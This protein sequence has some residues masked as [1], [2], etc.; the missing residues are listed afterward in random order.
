VLAARGPNA[1]PAMNLVILNTHSVRNS[2]DAAIVEAQLALLRELLPDPHITLTSRTPAEDAGFYAHLGVAAVLPPLFAA[3][4]IFPTS[5]RKLAGVAR[6]ALAFDAR[7]RLREAIRSA[8]LVVASGGGYLFSNRRRFPGPMFWQAWL[9][10]R[11]ALRAGRPVIFAPQSFG[12]FANARAA[13]AV[14]HLLDHDGVRTVLT[15]EPVSLDLLMRLLRGRPVAGRVTLCPD[16]AF[17]HGGT[18][19]DE[20]KPRRLPPPVLAITAREWAPVGG[21]R[22]ERAASR[23]AYLEALAGVVCRFCE[24][25]GGSVRVVVQSRGPGRLE[26]DRQISRELAAL[27]RAHGVPEE[28]LDLVEPEEAAPPGRLVAALRDVALLIATRFHSAILAMTAGRPAIAVGYQP[29]SLGMMTMLGLARYCVPMEALEPSRLLPLVDEVMADPERFADEHVRPAV[30][31][32]R[33]EAAAVMRR[34]LE[35]FRTD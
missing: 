6:S 28:R 30:A 33:R 2:G 18:A 15:R 24:G 1:R 7:R 31:A 11:L 3:P 23:R 32:A 25:Q 5:I 19:A 27:L 35:P 4:S 16:L 34:V 12:P 22:A 8:D 10:I 13:N 9:P 14:A 17:L 21:A 29:K 20:P 26:D